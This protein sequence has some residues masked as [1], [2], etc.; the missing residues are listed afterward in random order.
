MDLNQLYNYNIPHYKYIQ[1]S[2]GNWRT[3][4]HSLYNLLLSKF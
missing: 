3:N 2:G 1:L 4:E